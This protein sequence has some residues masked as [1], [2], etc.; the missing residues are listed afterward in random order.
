MLRMKLL[1]DDDFGKIIVRALTLKILR[2]SYSKL[3]CIYLGIDASQKIRSAGLH[4]GG[5]I[6]QQRCFWQGGQLTFI[7]LSHVL[8]ASELVAIW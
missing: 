4:R 6:L 1:V 2:H 8:T 7:N 3:A 5:K